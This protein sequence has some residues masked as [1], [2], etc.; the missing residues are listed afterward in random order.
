MFNIMAKKWV[1]LG[2]A[3]A[4]LVVG[5]LSFLIQ[6]FNT[7]ID[8]TGGIMLS[9]DMK[10]DFD[11]TEAEKIINDALGFKPSS[12][13]KTEGNGLVIKFAYQSGLNDK[14]S[15]EVFANEKVT[16]V[17]TKLTEKFGDQIV[18]ETQDEV[19]PSTGIELANN[20][21]W[22]SILA[23]F[24]ILI[25]VTLRFEFASG[26]VAIIALVINIGIM[27]TLYTLFRIPVNTS[28]IAAVLTVLGY[29]I[30]DTIIIFDRIRENVKFAK[31]ETYSEIVEKSIWQTLNRSINTVFTSVLTI[32]ILYIIGVPSIKEFSLPIIIGML[33]GACCSIFIAGPL[34]ATWKDMGVKGARNAK[35]A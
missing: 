20:A 21:F 22:M 8:F 19:S 26:T 4:I 25:Y 14:E 11:A 30:N 18:L 24:C 29:S 35:K 34:W 10:A 28:F 33:S 27:V 1:F 2:T 16:A 15:V 32:L 6:G 17:N 9:Y 13:Q 23:V 7:D 3:I 5:L 12:V 31:K